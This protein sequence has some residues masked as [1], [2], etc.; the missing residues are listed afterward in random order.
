MKIPDFKNILLVG[1]AGKTGIMY[2]RL[3]LK[4]GKRVFA[5]DKD[6][7]A[8]YSD[9]LIHDDN[10]FIVPNADLESGDILEKV[11]AVTLSP[12]VPLKQEIFSRSIEQNKILISE[13]EF[14]IPYLK[15]LR[16]IGVTGTDGKSTTVSLITHILNQLHIPSISCGNI[17]T[18]FSEVV[19]MC[20]KE[21]TLKFIV[22]EL[23]SYQLE[24][25]RNLKLEIAIL[26]NI[27][28][29][30]LE[31][32]E[33]QQEYE[34]TKWKI[35]NS[36]DVSGTFIVSSD[37]YKKRNDHT[38]IHGDIAQ[39][40]IDSMISSHFRWHIKNPATMQEYI[41]L[42]SSGQ[43][44]ISSDRLKIYGR[45]NL[46]NILFALENCRILLPDIDYAK[47][48]E[49]IQSYTSLPHRFELVAETKDTKYINDSKATTTQ[50]VLKA[51]ENTDQG[52]YLFMGG[53]SKGE[54]YSVIT[55]PLKDKK[56]KLFLFGENALQLDSTLRKGKCNVIGCYQNLEEAYQ[57]AYLHRQKNR[58]K[59]VTF[60]LSP[61]CTS[62]D[63]YKNFEERGEHFR[64]LV[65]IHI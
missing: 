36:I 5:Y 39:V 12:G 62:W 65:D 24:L 40:D 16:W 53:R 19:M 55:K 1:A 18:P 35:A 42:D 64:R 13:L 25:A 17:G 50:S 49:V 29:D 48:I 7:S 21:S 37:L 11:E 6:H 3:L 2:A 47:F 54:D 8:S 59:K 9:E 10:F 30:H 20:Q 38:P 26:L 4:E 15:Q 63:Q 41:L 60:L 46:T 22:A 28:S 56:A 44:M 34:D 31:R 57:A 51:I 58:G 32:Y 14:C 27:S 45:H 61:G 33:S 43:E 23:S 52:V